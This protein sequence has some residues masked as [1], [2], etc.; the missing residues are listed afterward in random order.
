MQAMASSAGK[1]HTP[2]GKIAIL[3]RQ[4]KETHE[5]LGRAE[6]NAR[7]WRKSYLRVIQLLQDA[8][9]ENAALQARVRQLEI[10]ADAVGGAL[11]FPLQQLQQAIL[12]DPTPYPLL[13]CR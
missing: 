2:E 12:A 8:K 1:R 4:L 7:V 10:C 9:T 11:V 3:E 13:Q 6:A 5:Q